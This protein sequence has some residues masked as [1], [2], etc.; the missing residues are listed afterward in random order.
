MRIR[1]RGLPFLFGMAALAAAVSPGSARA[2]FGLAISGVGPI[3]RAMG[4]AAVAAPL[5]AAGAVYWNPATIGAL[6]RSE[7][8]VG[9]QILIPRTTLSSRIPP[10]ALGPGLPPVPLRGNDGSNIGVFPLPT[11]GLVYRPDP[12][13]RW[14]FGFG[15]FEIGGFGVNYPVDPRNP[16]LMPQVP[17]GRGVGPL[18]TNL[19]LFQ[20]TPTVAYQATDRL[21]VGASANIDLGYL[22]VNPALFAPPTLVQT[23]LGP[24][25]VYPSATHGRSRGG[26]GFQV[27]LYYDP[28]TD[29]H[30]GAS[31]KSPQWFDTY[32]FNA[33]S[34][35]GRSTTPKINLD[36]PLIGSIGAAYTGIDSLLIATDLRIVDYR[37]TNGF[38]H[39]G[40]DARGTLRGLGWQNVFALASGIQYRATDALA[41]RA[42]YTFSLNPVGPAMTSFN[43]GSPTIIQHSLAVGASYDLSRA[44]RVSIAYVH[45]FQNAIAGPLVQ[46]FI[47]PIPGSRVRTAATGDSVVVGASVAF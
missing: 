32:T 10:G 46:P 26:G 13:S 37:D 28:H 45:D 2:Q 4:G 29:W 20:F 25:P 15:A 17:F 44:F 21:A 24:G 31:V 18:Y 41:L 6:G 27:G 34:A 22:S 12:T 1:R 9:T 5:D 39:S 40:F 43:I 8:E 47:G 35:I 19:Q 16:I 23:P 11:F 7:M 30:F 36:F 3:N 38:R 42:G 14:T 33:V